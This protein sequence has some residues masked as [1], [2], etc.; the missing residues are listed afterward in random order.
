[1]ET[2]AEE[3]AW[4]LRWAVVLD[5]LKVGMS[6]AEGVVLSPAEC[7]TLVRGVNALS[8]NTEVEPG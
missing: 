4:F 6:S 8:G 7:A 1:M 2:A 5:K 3:A